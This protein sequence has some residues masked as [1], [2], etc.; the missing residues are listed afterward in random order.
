MV[1]DLQ[2]KLNKADST[3]IYYSQIPYPVHIPI[4]RPVPVKIIIPQPYPIE[5][6]VIFCLDIVK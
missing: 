6:R 3:I 2:T 5:K 4:D 1:R